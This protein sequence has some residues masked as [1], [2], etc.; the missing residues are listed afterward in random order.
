MNRALR[1]PFWLVLALL[2]AFGAQAAAPDFDGELLGIQ[3]A[4]AVANYQTPDEAA[5]KR[6]FESLIERAHAF[7][8][9][10]PQRAEA[11]IWEGIVL[12][13]YA[14]VKGGLGALGLAKRSRAALEQAMQL[15]PNALE[16]SAYTSLGALYSKVPGFPVGFGNDKK[17]RELLQKAV[18]INP[19]GIDANYFY[20]DFLIEQKEYAQARAYLQKALQAPARP[21]REVA[22]EGRRGEIN[23]LL[24]RIATKSG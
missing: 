18:S 13:T 20:G 5:R 8:A 24:A 17:A 19:N 1:N 22:D 11:L 7:S 16:G 14:G 12:S 21:G 4:W 15:D 10:N 2:G 3:Q 23:T 9:A 6:A